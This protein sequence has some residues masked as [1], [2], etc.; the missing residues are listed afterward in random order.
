MLPSPPPVDAAPSELQGM[1]WELAAVNVRICGI[2]GELCCVSVEPSWVWCDVKRV[3][4]TVVQIPLRE[5]RLYSADSELFDNVPVAE[6]S[7]GAA[8]VE[9][10][11][12]RRPP[13]QAHWLQRVAKAW[14]VENPLSKA[15]EH[16]QADREIVLA[17]IRQNVGALRYASAELRADPEVVLSAVRPNRLALRQVVEH[18]AP[19]LWADRDFALAA[20]ERNGG[21]LQYVAAE[22]Q[23][24]SEVVLVAVQQNTAELRHAAPELLANKDFLLSVVQRDGCALRYAA[25]TLKADRG[26]VFA[27]VQQNRTALRF[28]AMELRRDKR[29]LARFS[30]RPSPSAPIS[31]VQA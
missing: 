31:T 22:L 19:E 11:L 24:D 9:L 26:I 30:R 4:E 7:S 21:A 17:A 14:F 8:S 12:V 13:E 28:A 25:E 29:M 23:G 15:P 2:G 3:I 20:V 1:A 18:A 6:L 27:A 16:I 5:Q 10:T